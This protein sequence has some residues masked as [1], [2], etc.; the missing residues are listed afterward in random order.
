M[1]ATPEESARLDVDIADTG[2]PDLKKRAAENQTHQYPGWSSA[3]RRLKLARRAIDNRALV[4]D[5]LVACG[6]MDEAAQVY[7]SNAA[8][9]RSRADSSV[10]C[11]AVDEA[12]A[13]LSRTS[14]LVPLRP[15]IR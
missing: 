7:V 10:A 1:L 3:L 2:T 13:L 5:S 11:S 4:A 15:Q 12:S 9:V 8:V 6:A 14:T